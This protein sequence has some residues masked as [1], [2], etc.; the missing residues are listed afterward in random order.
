[1]CA[2]VGWGWVR[3]GRPYDRDLVTRLVTDLGAPCLV[4]SGLVGL[5][6]GSDELLIVVSAALLGMAC[7]ASIGA[8]VLRVARLPT[9]TYLAPLVFG[10]TGNMGL[11]LCLFAFGETGLALAVCFFA[12]V[13]V[14]HY[15]A[16]IWLW[17]GRVSLV[18]LL[19]TPLFWAAVL[20]VV[21]LVVGVPL[22]LWVRNTTE[23]LGGLTIP[24]MLM[25]MGVSLGELHL[26]DLP[27]TAALST[28]RLGMGVAVGFAVAAWL[29]LEGV[30]RG[31][32]IV[33]C[34]MPVAVFN[35]LFAERYG[36]S[37]EAV[38]SLVV[39]STLLAFIMLPFLLR[40]VL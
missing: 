14:T 22:P 26:S 36:R 33:E 31:V 20:A 28:L 1:M 9:H 3:S 10:N 19:H 6:A 8:V 18:E 5:D 35:Y 11:P 34:A 4:F 13:A 29:E 37:P 2:G 7:F 16:G 17:S 23:L 15:S 30:V 32:V 21:V 25:T 24:L 27:R 38:A 39:F 40:A 12:T